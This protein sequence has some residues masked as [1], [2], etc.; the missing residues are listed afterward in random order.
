[1]ANQ[2]VLDMPAI[3]SRNPGEAIAAAEVAKQ[4]IDLIVMS[5]KRRPLLA[6]LLGSTAV[7]FWWRVRR[8]FGAPVISIP[9]GSTP[10]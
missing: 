3:T 9:G 6:T 2:P 4:E 8:R 7:R 10:D 5:P 1:M